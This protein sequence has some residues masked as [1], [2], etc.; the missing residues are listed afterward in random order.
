LNRERERET[1]MDPEQI[2]EF[3]VGYLKKKG[4]SSAAKDLES[5]HHQNNNGSSFTSVDY[6]ND[7]ELTKLIR[8]FSQ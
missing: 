4:F 5:Y 8:S 2:N 3:V 7:P 6:H 1:T